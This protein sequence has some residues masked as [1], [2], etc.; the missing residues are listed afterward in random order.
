MNTSP[1][2]DASEHDVSKPSGLSSRSAPASSGDADYQR[3]FYEE[4]SK[5]VIQRE[6]SIK[7]WFHAIRLVVAILAVVVPV[8]DEAYSHQNRED[9]TL[10]LD[11]A[12]R[13][14]LD[15]AAAH[16]NRGVEE[17]VQGHY[18]GALADFDAAIRL[19][20][21]D[22]VAY[23]NRGNTKNVQGRHVEALADFDAAIRLNPDDAA[24]LQQSGGMRRTR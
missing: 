9:S 21:E 6:R 4:G 13:L 14:N 3:R 23:Y 5:R 1:V 11:E 19:N 15:D 12:V 16:N 18:A 24:A 10:A 8:A 22:A 2:K 7:E 17:Y 20:P